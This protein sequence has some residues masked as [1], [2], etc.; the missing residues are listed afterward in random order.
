MSFA[1]TLV[2]GT[3]AGLTI[4]LGLPIAKVRAVQ[5]K[6]MAFLNALA[7]GILLFLFVEITTHAAGPVEDAMKAGRSDV[8]L[9]L[10]SLVGGFVVGFLSLVYYG[11]RFMTTAAGSGQRLALLIALGIGLHNFSE[12]LAIGNS[13]QRGELA[14]ALTL[15]VGFAL[16]NVTEAFGIA[17]PVA[18]AGVGWGTLALAGVIAGGPNFFGTIIGYNFASA[19]VSVVFLA[20]AAG[21]LVFVIG[22]LFAA[23]R[24]L[25][26]PVWNG[27]GLAVG[28]LAALLTDFFLVAAGG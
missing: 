21:A 19:E 24:R 8:P 9:L 7:I 26:A 4:F 13:A 5:P 16:H 12:G 27:W 28:F 3:V 10:A 25:T 11:R 18:G 22:E 23:G 6:H 17:A 20:L 1:Q 2:L 15:V 14:L